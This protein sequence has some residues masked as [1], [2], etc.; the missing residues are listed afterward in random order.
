M[1]SHLNLSRYRELVGRMNDYARLYYSEDRPVISDYEYDQLYRD[2]V[3]FESEYPDCVDPSSP[4]QRVGD[5]PLEQFEPFTHRLQLPSLNNVFS[6]EELA[7]FHTRVLK[8]AETDRVAFAVE[9]KMDG[10]AVSL[11]YRKGK[12]EVG[13]T[14]GDGITGE[15]V[16]SNLRTIRSLPLVL[17]EPI[18]IEVRGEVFM[19][20][21]VFETLK[22]EFANPRNAAAGS[23]RQLDPRIAS[24][25][26]L[27]LM[28]YQ[29]I[30]PGIESHQEMVSFLQKLGFLASSVTIAYTVEE[31]DAACQEKRDHYDWEIDGAVVKVNSFRLQ[32]AMGFTTKAP[33]WA[34][35][36]KFPTSQAVTRLEDI[37]VQVG[38]TGVLTPVAVLAPVQVRGVVVRRATLHNSEDIERKDVC[39]GDDVLIQRAGDVIPEVVK[40]VRRFPESRVF[41]MPKQC[42]CCG[43]PVVKLVGEVATRCQNVSCP[44]QLKGRLLHFVSRD[45]LDIEG[46]GKALVDQLTDSGLVKQIPD[47]Y[48]LTHEQLAGLERMGDK[49]ADNVLESLAKSRRCRL[50]QFVY[51]LGIPFV[52]IYTARTLA[53]EFRSLDRI[54]AAN[55]AELDAAPDIGEKTAQSLRTSFE[56]RHFQRVVAE[57]LALGFRISAPERVAENGGKLQGKRFLVTGTLSEWTRKEAEMRIEQLGGKVVS[58][59]S[60]ELSYLVV[61]EEPGSKLEKVKRLNA[62]G[63]E[64][65]ILPEEAFKALVG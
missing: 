52:G 58:A 23:L 20:Q 63:A 27:D 5:R 25:R 10:L 3:A 59:P 31:I 15:N 38:R 53:Q 11:Y 28:A 50:D 37:I 47:L 49:S 44:A 65:V 6:G 51:A 17:P 18:D 1:P 2:L 30:Y 24:K 57:L 34:V 8:E 7:A 46:F 39:I 13:A 21:S 55:Q 35:A 14:R 40:S 29:G 19:R 16:T 12:L 60:A 9:P 64:I 48:R 41:H 61:G 43:S 45:A 54:L 32:E 56:D 42:P 4:T 22:E 26:R 36:F 62:K 33:R